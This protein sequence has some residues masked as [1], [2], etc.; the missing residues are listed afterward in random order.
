M[1]DAGDDA[2]VRALLDD[3][4]GLYARDALPRWKELFLNGFVAAAPAAD[5]GV[6]TWSLDEFY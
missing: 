1:S 5:G 2:A 6:A 3:Y 4:I